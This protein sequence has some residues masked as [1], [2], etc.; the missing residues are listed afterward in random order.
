MCELIISN[1]YSVHV[2]TGITAFFPRPGTDLGAVTQ[3][4]DVGLNSS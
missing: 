4:L 3:Q 1:V 2:G